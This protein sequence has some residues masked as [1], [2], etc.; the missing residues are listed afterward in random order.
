MMNEWL[1]END[2]HH[3]LRVRTESCDSAAATSMDETSCSPTRRRNS[4]SSM[5][6]S[7]NYTV[8]QLNTQISTPVTASSSQDLGFGSAKKRWLRQAMTESTD[9]VPSAL[10]PLNEGEMP[11]PASVVAV[12]NASSPSELC[13]DFV[14]PLKKRRLARSSLSVEPSISVVESSTSKNLNN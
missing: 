4:T 8:R 13:S 5:A 7:P 6:V 10:V 3:P 1:S 2:N 12:N 9:P 14:T 11:S